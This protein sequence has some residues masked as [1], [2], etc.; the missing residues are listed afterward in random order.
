MNGITEA[1]A[2]VLS[3]L[4]TKMPDVETDFSNEL[5]ELGEISFAYDY[6]LLGTL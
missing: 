6:F 5:K 4:A 1:R 2:D 3:E